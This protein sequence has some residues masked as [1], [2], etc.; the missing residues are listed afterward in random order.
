MGKDSHLEPVVEGTAVLWVLT[1]F[2]HFSASKV[3]ICFIIQVLSA[4]CCSER[5]WEQEKWLNSET[6]PSPFPPSPFFHVPS[7]TFPHK[8]PN[9][10]PELRFLLL[11]QM[12]RNGRMRDLRGLFGFRIIKQEDEKMWRS[13]KN[14]YAVEAAAP[15]V[16]PDLSLA[17]NELD[18]A[19]FVSW[20][21]GEI[22]TQIGGGSQVNSIQPPTFTDK[23]AAPL[24][25]SPCN[26]W[27]K[28]SA[29]LHL[30]TCSWSV[31]KMP[32]TSCFVRYCCQIMVDEEN[33]FWNGST[34][35]TPD[36]ICALTKPK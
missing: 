22:P 18:N 24:W 4:H 33:H 12:V 11:F 15:E 31:I 16:G 21:K 36:V 27:R 23:Q 35:H 2:C 8:W 20:S 34:P 13:R 10:L 14:A 25:L 1:R 5:A 7:P 17:E 28:A 9:T 26:R 19:A 32:P 6:C 30:F 3:S 29:A